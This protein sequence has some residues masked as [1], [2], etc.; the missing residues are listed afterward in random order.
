MPIFTPKDS[1]SW[2]GL[3]L[4]LVLFVGLARRDD[5]LA[6]RDFRHGHFPPPAALGGRAVGIGLDA[7]HRRARARARTF[8]RGFE[9]GD[10]VDFLRCRTERRGMGDEVDARSAT[11]GTRA[12]FA[13]VV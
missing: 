13:Q 8:Q 1:I 10:A 12:V 5:F 4:L 3:L 11:R 9:S 6:L 7:D 2:S